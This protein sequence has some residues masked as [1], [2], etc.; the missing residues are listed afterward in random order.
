MT[1]GAG[2]AGSTQASALAHRHP[3]GGPGL[4]GSGAQGGGPAHRVDLVLPQHEEVLGARWG[5]ARQPPRA[6]LAGQ[7]RLSV[8]AAVATGPA[9]P[10]GESEPVLAA[11]TERAVVGRGAGGSP[12][13]ELGVQAVLAD[14]GKRPPDAP[15]A[16]GQHVAR[17]GQVDR[18]AGP[19]GLAERA[20]MT[21]TVATQSGVWVTCGFTYLVCAPSRV[22]PLGGG[23]RFDLETGLAL[24]AWSAVGVW[25]TPSPGRGAEGRVTGR[26]VWGPRE[27]AG[28]G[29]GQ[30]D[31]PAE[32]GGAAG[33]SGHLACG[34]GLGLVQASGGADTCGTRLPPRGRRDPCQ[35]P[36][37]PLGAVAADLDGDLCSCPTGRWVMSA[38]PPRARPASGWDSV[39][40][41][42]HRV[43]IKCT[44]DWPVSGRI[45][46]EAGNTSAGHHKVAMAAQLLSSACIESLV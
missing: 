34:C 21:A 1:P 31:A 7:G 36:G 16:S 10:V 3:L 40:G 27:G 9:R 28:C 37:W 5:R 22:A 29:P 25:W 14:E 33:R 45:G 41:E 11:T 26:A 12:G 8:R 32:C 38:E 44:S 20:A 13:S 23:P 35:A 30:R 19:G 6:F 2:S 42:C 39:F 4:R 43:H 15:L 18:A 46:F 24:T 17:V